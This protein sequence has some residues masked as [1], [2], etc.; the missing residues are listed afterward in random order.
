MSLSGT[1]S[2]IV[3]VV[4]GL[5]GASKSEINKRTGLSLDYIGYI[6]RFLTKK[7]YLTFSSGRYHLAGAPVETEK[8]LVSEI[9]EA[10]V[11]RIGVS[12]WGGAGEK[13][14]EAG[15]QVKI[16][17]DFDVSIQDESLELESNINKVGTKSET[18]KFNINKLI[19]SLTRVRKGGK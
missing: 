16:K 12:R 13:P 6:C 19:D 1:E 2:E 5:K 15:R 8:S 4:A 17:T 10:V 14:A 7:G 11:Q 3:K 18:E 9:A